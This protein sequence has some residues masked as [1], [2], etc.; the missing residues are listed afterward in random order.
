V[1]QIG[2]YGVVEADLELLW[3]SW[4]AGFLG[5]R[6][7]IQCSSFPRLSEGCL[8]TLDE[9]ISRSG[10]KSPL[11]TPEPRGARGVVDLQLCKAREQRP[12]N[13]R[14]V[15]NNSGRAGGGWGRRRRVRLRASREERGGR[16]AAEKN[17]MPIQQAR[18]PRRPARHGA[19]GGRFGGGGC[20]TQ[21]LGAGAGA[22]GGLRRPVAPDW[23]TVRR[24][25]TPGGRGGARETEPMRDA[26]QA[27]QADTDAGVPP[28]PHRAPPTA[29]ARWRRLD[30]GATAAECTGQ[31]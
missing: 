6:L 1:F 30:R 21:R 5:E 12:N 9:F 31:W 3:N 2:F 15:L 18:M 29:P 22:R 28:P 26:R 4:S 24:G 11:L 17:T 20:Q 8:A 27:V 7:Y 19:V 16:A 14:R 10:I 25:R 23:A 13:T